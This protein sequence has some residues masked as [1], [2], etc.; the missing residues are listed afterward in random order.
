MITV[1]ELSEDI[2]IAAGQREPADPVRETSGGNASGFFVEREAYLK[3]FERK[4]LSEVLKRH[5]GDVREAAEEAKIPRGT[6]YRLM[7]KHGLDSSDF[8]DETV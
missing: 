2:V 3:Q 4:Y 8:R 5:D 1:D 7:K 6:L